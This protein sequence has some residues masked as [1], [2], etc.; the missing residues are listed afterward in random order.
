MPQP[1]VP[2][3]SFPIKRQPRSR[4]LW[5]ILVPVSIVLVLAIVFFT[6]LL[7]LITHVVSTPLSSTSNQPRKPTSAFQSA[8]CPFSIGSGIV[9]GK[10]VR[11][12]YVTVPENRQ[13]TNGASVRLAVAVFKSPTVQNDSLPVFRVEGGAGGR[14]LDDWAH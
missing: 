12:G 13:H 11:C 8:A 6:L 1:V 2:Q 3:P 4:L 9:E 7:P 14:S 5:F 10:D